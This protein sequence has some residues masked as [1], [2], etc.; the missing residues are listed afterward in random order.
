MDDTDRELMIQINGNPRIQIRELAKR[1]GISKQA[2]HHRMQVLMEKGVIRGMTAGISVSYLDAVPVAIS[3]PSKT[4]SIEKTLDRL[5]KSEFTR[6]VIVCG[7]NYLY[8]VGF[9]RNVSELDGY[10]EFVKREG[11]IVD[12][13]VGI[14]CL[15]DGLMPGYCVDGGGEQ[16]KAHK[17]LSALDLKIIA[18][19]RNNARRP[20]AE[21]AAMVGVSAKTV[22]RHLDSMMADGS[23]DMNMPYDGLSGGDMFL[24]M[25][26]NLMNGADKKEVGRRLISK[27]YFRDHYVRTY[28]NIPNFLVWVFWSDKIADIRKSLK[29]TSED[30]DVQSVMLNFAYSERIYPTWRDRLTDPRPNPSEMI[31][32]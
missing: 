21:I 7:G 3:G 25:H 20:V 28:S 14:Y 4:A 1:L 24:V 23:L 2:V 15:D 6:R 9:L 31:R 5:G 26:V 18:S 13:I 29:E 8:V 32:K 19:L 27:H 12:P 17:E 22:R 16:R 30:E 10:V 11:E